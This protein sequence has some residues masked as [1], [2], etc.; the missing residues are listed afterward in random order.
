MNS[1]GDDNHPQEDDALNLNDP[2]DQRPKDTPPNAQEPICIGSGITL[3]KGG[4]SPPPKM[5]GLI[6]GLTD[7][8]IS[9][10]MDQLRDQLPQLRGETIAVSL[11]IHE[12]TYTHTPPVR[13]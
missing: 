1:I 5:A 2:A 10:V 3:P 7:Q 4:S 6:Q 12:E 9:S 8:I 13:T 11:F